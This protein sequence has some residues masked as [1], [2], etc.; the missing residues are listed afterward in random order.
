MKYWLAPSAVPKDTPGAPVSGVRRSP[1]LPAAARACSAAAPTQLPRSGARWARPQACGLRAG[2]E[3]GLDCP[4]ERLFVEYRLQRK[5]ALGAAAT[6][7]AAA[8]EEDAALAELENLEELE[9]LEGLEAEEGGAGDTA[10]GPD[11]EDAGA[12]PSDEL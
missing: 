3:R 10:L 9:A 7:L 12:E 6:R 5:R 8:L 1:A 11:S 2:A 4:L